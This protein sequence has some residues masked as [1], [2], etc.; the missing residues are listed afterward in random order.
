MKVNSIKTR[1]VLISLICI[2]G[3]ILLCGAQH[4]YVAKYSIHSDVQS[5]TSSLIQDVSDL[6][7]LEQYYLANNDEQYI[8]KFESQL[9][10]VNAAFSELSTIKYNTSIDKKTTTMLA[11][12]LESYRDAFYQ[13]RRARLSDSPLID[14][15][16]INE[17]TILE[18]TLAQQAA[19]D[20][21]ALKETLVELKL[22]TRSFF[23]TKLTKDAQAIDALSHKLYDHNLYLNS[24]M[25]IEEIDQYRGLLLDYTDKYSSS[26][27]KRKVALNFALIESAS[28]LESYLVGMNELAHRKLVKQRDELLVFVSVVAVTLLVCALCV[29]ITSFALFQRSFSSLVTFFYRSFRLQQKIDLRYVELDEFKTFATMANELIVDRQKMQIKL[30]SA[31]AE[32]A[33]IKND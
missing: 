17:L 11:D 20:E 6:R 3:L 22:I 24:V 4:I 14:E 16:L 28:A 19:P 8:R 32:L 25:P 7:K 15:E 33:L 5:V 12:A 18:H 27:S 30:A 13:M 1:F 23:A 31:E 9:T 10:K 2:V 21:T 26:S 29:F